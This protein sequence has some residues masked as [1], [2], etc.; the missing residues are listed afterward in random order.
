MK[1]RLLGKMSDFV[2]ESLPETLEKHPETLVSD[3]EKLLSELD[4]YVVACAAYSDPRTRSIA[5]LDAKMIE[6]G[7]VHSGFIPPVELTK[8][9]DRLSG[10]APPV[11]TYDELLLLNP[12]RD[13]RTFTRGEI[14]ETEA[15]FY[16]EQRF[17]EECLERTIGKMRVAIDFLGSNTLDYDLSTKRAVRALAGIESDLVPAIEAV[18]GLGS[19]PEGHFDVF[20]P[21]VNPHPLR[22]LKGPSG[23]FSAR[24]QI[25][26]LLLHG[27]EFPPEYITYFEENR[28]YF[29]KQGQL[30]IDDA[31]EQARKGDTLLSLWRNNGRS[32]SIKD[33]LVVIGKFL[34]NFRKVH[35][36]SVAKQVPSIIRGDAPG[37]G[38][39]MNSGKFLRERKKLAKF[40]IEEK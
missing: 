15:M 32:D 7:I 19:M 37:T 14:R 25:V 21:Y 18:D 34:N 6:A 30:E 36:R 10:E 16:L 39:E 4:P 23:A 38:G 35:Y 5:S 3:C 17:I 33:R 31:V 1:E 24:V 26:D 13:F 12:V 29:P 2:R 9:V 20:R 11:I 27:E 40:S 28:Q 22:N 8:L